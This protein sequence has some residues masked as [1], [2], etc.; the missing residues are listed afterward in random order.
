MK[1]T[2]KYF[3][4]YEKALQKSSESLINPEII[5]I[6]DSYDNKKH[7]IN[8]KYLAVGTSWI[9][10]NNRYTDIFDA[11]NSLCELDSNNKYKIIK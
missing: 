9:N 5:T 8:Y 7:K 2:I 1:K 6:V 11:N 3:K 4:Q 10:N